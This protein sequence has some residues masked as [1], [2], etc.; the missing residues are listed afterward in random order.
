MIRRPPRSTLF[1]YTTLFRSQTV[2][3]S[4]IWLACRYSGANPFQP[5]RQHSWHL[6]RCH[7]AGAAADR[8]T[9]TFI[10][11]YHALQARFSSAADVASYLL[12]SLL[13][14]ARVAACRSGPGI[15]FAVAAMARHVG[16]RTDYL[17]GGAGAHALRFTRLERASQLRP[18]DHRRWNSSG[19][20]RLPH[21]DNRAQS[22]DVTACFSN[23]C[24]SRRR[25]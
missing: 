7:S 22:R 2:L 3:E 10:R 24:A 1:P 21:R 19:Q 6:A 15:S 18:A 23:N 25:D 9:E 11:N 16:A 13:S 5:A 12:F 17:G 20:P 8:A 4:E 14:L